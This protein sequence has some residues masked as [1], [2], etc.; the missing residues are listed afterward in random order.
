MP[1][2]PCASRPNPPVRSRTPGLRATAAPSSPRALPTPSRTPIPR[3]PTSTPT[4][5]PVGTAAAAP[6]EGGYSPVVVR[7]DLL[8]LGPPSPASQSANLDSLFTPG[9]GVDPTRDI[10][11]FPVA[12]LFRNGQSVRYDP[13]SHT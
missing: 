12:H 10:I 13:Q 7:R 3:A 5:T 4:E 9:P 1:I 11:R 6:R 2:S 8:R